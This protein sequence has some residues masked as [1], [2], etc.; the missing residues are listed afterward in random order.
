M[1]SCENQEGKCELLEFEADKEMKPVIAEID[2]LFGDLLY[3]KLWP[4][5]IL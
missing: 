1:I 3:L 2:L 4:E 5:G